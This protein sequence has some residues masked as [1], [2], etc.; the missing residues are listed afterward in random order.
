MAETMIVR[1]RNLLPELFADALILLHPLQTT[2]AIASGT[3]QTV[4]DHLYHF[5]IFIQPNCHTAFPPFQGKLQI[6]I[7]IRTQKRIRILAE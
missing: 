5:L 3:L 2:G 4:F 7:K 6:N 1:I